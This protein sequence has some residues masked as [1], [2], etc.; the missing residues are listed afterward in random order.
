MNM[1]EINKMVELLAG[2]DG[3]GTFSNFLDFSVSNS[4]WASLSRLIEFDCTQQ[5]LQ[6]LNMT[7][8][9]ICR[10]PVLFGVLQ[11]RR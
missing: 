4:R 2:N 11:L 3:K 5:D 10:E 8:K 7:F 9:R 6:Y 1:L